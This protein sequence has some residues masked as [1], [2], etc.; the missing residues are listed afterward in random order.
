MWRLRVL[1]QKKLFISWKKLKDAIFKL[2]SSVF[3]ILPKG[4]W[5][6]L[7]QIDTN[8]TESRIWPYVH[9][10]YIDVAAC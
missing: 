10:A 1:T 6:K 5:A 8:V 2:K 3:C 4:N 7:L 9:C